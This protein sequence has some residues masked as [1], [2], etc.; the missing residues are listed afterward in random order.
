MTSLSILCAAMHNWRYYQTL[1][2]KEKNWGRKMCFGIG[3]RNILTIFWDRFFVDICESHCPDFIIMTFKPFKIH[4]NLFTTRMLGSSLKIVLAK[5]PYWFYLREI[6]RKWSFF[7]IIYTF[8][9]GYNKFMYKVYRK[10]TMNGHFI[11]HYEADMWQVPFPFSVPQM[12]LSFICHCISS[13]SKQNKI[14]FSILFFLSIIAEL[15]NRPK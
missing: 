8:L 15:Y 12:S 6:N 7:Y 11:L 3:I 5:Q 14:I 10:M 1:K 4:Q 13:V 2:K 9:F